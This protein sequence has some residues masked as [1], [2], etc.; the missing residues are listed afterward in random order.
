MHSVV[1]EIKACMPVEQR[2]AI[3]KHVTR[4]TEITLKNEKMI[5]IFQ[6]IADQKFP[7]FKTTLA[8]CHALLY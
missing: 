1:L 4:I 8:R 5:R 6:R 2:M 7:I 3:D